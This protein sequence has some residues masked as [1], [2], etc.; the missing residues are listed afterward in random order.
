MRGS[1]R[2]P[3]RLAQHHTACLVGYSMNLSCDQQHSLRFMESSMCQPGTYLIP[4]HERSPLPRLRTFFGR[5]ALAA[6]HISPPLWRQAGDP[7]PPGTERSIPSPGLASS[8]LL[9]WNKKRGSDLHKQTSLQTC[10][11]VCAHTSTSA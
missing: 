1:Q 3:R 6:I 7:Q 5:P 4:D 11:Q 2:T 8:T 10:Q 9:D